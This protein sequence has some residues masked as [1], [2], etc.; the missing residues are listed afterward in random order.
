MPAFSFQQMFPLSGDTTEYRR[1]TDEHV[2]VA[3]FE[4][5]DLVR[6]APE[7]L[8]LLAEQAFT[9]VAHLL[10]GSHL[11]QLSDIFEDP[12]S[13]SNDR[14]VA[15]EL[16]KNAVIAA[17]GIFPMCQDTGT[18]VIIG[19]KGQRIWTAADDEAALAEG[20]FNAYVRGNLRYSQNAPLS[21]YA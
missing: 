6:V 12:Q 7:A 1:L 20:A 10:R 15:L 17:E 4:G 21:M 18:A 9:D 11:Q 3:E 5:T 19:K 2:S 8:T 16:L 13:S 14:Y